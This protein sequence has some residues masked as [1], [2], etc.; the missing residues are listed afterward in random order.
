M[1]GAGAGTGA[2]GSAPAGDAVANASSTP[3]A[4]PANTVAIVTV[5][6]DFTNDPS[7]VASETVV[8]HGSIKNQACFVTAQ[9]LHG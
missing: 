6:L 9:S 2:T 4:H 8:A 3:D 7:P 5:F 1:G